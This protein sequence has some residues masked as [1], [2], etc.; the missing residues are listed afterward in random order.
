MRPNPGWVWA[1]GD[2]R[3]VSW[4][5]FP[6]FFSQVELGRSIGDQDGFILLRRSQENE[7]FLHSISA[8]TESAQAETKR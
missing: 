2:D 4:T 1:E 7:S 8:G 3:N 6:K 5:D